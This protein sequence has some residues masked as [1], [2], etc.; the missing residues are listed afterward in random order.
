MGKSKTHLATNRQLWALNVHGRL[1][2]VDKAEPVTADQAAVVIS[3]A[4]GSVDSVEQGSV[5]QALE[6]HAEL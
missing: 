2:V 3:E 6:Q 1:L 5:E 4:K